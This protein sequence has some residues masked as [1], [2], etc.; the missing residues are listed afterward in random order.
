MKTLVIILNDTRSHELT[1]NNFKKNVI[2]ELNADLCL[3]IGV[4]P[5]YDYN[6]PFYKLAKYKFTYNEPDDYADAFDYAYNLIKKPKYEFLNNIN[7]LHS[8]IQCPRISNDNITYYGDIE[9]NIY[10][11][12]N[13]MFDD[14]EIIITTNNYSNDDW[15]NQIYG[16]KNSDNNNLIKEENIITL[17]KPLHWREF[18]KIKDQ[19]LGGIKDIN[20]QHPGSGAVQIFYRWFLLKNLIDNNLINEYDR[21]IVTRSDYMYKLPFPKVEKM[22]INNIWIPDEEHYHGY[23]DR[24][25][26]LSKTNIISYLDILNNIILKSNEYFMNMKNKNDWNIE[27]LIKFHLEKNNLIHLVKEFPYIMY[28]CRLLTTPTRWTSTNPDYFDTLGNYV[29]YI[30]EYNKSDEY[31]YKYIHSGLT[32]DEFYKDLY[33]T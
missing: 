19:F 9:S 13:D 1:Y 3:C 30:S 7:A 18:L 32:I 33:D 23:T 2:D 8:K 6:N 20:H 17:K 26:I 29:K 12:N 4:K 31:L 27:Q 24:C 10:K 11:I 21:F 14:D 28:T 25:V 16:I 15:K 5:D 22:N